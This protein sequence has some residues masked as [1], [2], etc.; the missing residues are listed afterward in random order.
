MRLRTVLTGITVVTAA[1][2]LVVCG[3]LIGLTTTLH[4]ISTSLAAAVESVRL[5]EEAEVGLLLH[6]RSSDPV[7]R[8]EH[9]ADVRAR[10]ASVRQLVTSPGEAGAL[11]RAVA[12]VD[13][14]FEAER[15]GAAV[16]AL[17]TLH[18]SAFGA[19]E[20][21]IDLEVAH[22]RQARDRAARSDR[23]ADLIGVAGAFTVLGLAGALAWW[24]RRRAFRP[25]L[26]LAEVMKRFGAGDRAARMVEEGPLEVRDMARHFNQMA[27]TLAEQRERQAAFLAGV[28]HDLRNPLAALATATELVRPEAP[29]PAEPVLRRL[30]Q[31]VRRQVVGLDRMVGDLMDMASIE[32][33]RFGLCLGEHDLRGIVRHLAEL[34]RPIARDGRIEVA[35]TDGPVVVRCDEGR[36]QQVIGNLLSNAIKYSVEAAQVD[37]RLRADDAEAV[38]AVRDRGVGMSGDELRALFEPYSRV[39]A[40]SGRTRG[41]G[42]GLFVARRI[43][44]AHGG[45]LTVE[46]APGRGS[47]FEVRLPCG[48]RPDVGAPASGP[49]HDAGEGTPQREPLHQHREHDD[50]VGHGHDGVARA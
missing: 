31:S 42:L 48:A 44:E 33:G 11:D 10:L 15:R 20:A 30:V 29:L 18:A 32:A 41:V 37:V 6:G 4:R 46:S 36:L 22:S 9:E 8:R 19:L 12:A 35:V 39:G 16:A 45:R 13:A 1:L 24:L 14:Y 17:T 2:A 26:A 23:V 43:V 3:A 49:R 40:G 34:Y 38:I 50:H 47:T 7:V 21:L 5:A 25:V 28:A 27:A